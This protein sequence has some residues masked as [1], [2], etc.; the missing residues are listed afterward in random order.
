MSLHHVLDH[1]L[2]VCIRLHFA[3]TCTGAQKVT[4]PAPFG[5]LT[6]RGPLD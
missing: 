3:C 4:V 5:S 2:N 6:V 1:L